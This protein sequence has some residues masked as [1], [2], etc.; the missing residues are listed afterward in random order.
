MS[1]RDEATE[2]VSGTYR[3]LDYTTDV[4]LHPNF[5]NTAANL[6]L[7]ALR[8]SKVKLSWDED[9][10]ERDRITRRTLTRQEIEEN[11]FKAYLASDTESESDGDEGQKKMDR[12]KL[13]ALLL[14][15]GDD[16]LPEGWG[17]SFDDDANDVDMEI[18]FAPGLSTAKGGENET[19]LEKYQRKMKEKKKKRKEEVKEKVKEKDTKEKKVDAPKDDFFADGSDDE[20]EDDEEQEVREELPVKKAKRDK[21]TKAKAQTDHEDSPEQERHAATTEELTL[22]AVS[23]NPNGELKH[24]DMKAVLKAEKAKGKKHK[25]RKD[26]KKTE[27][28]NDLQE[29]FA[30]DVKD[31]RFQAVLEDHTFAIDPSNPQ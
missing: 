8:H 12:E 25:H 24:F 28:G 7:Q 16:T 4:D 20:D 15:G 13:R 27:E 17:A 14:S 5:F 3:P 10:P 2:D 29:D 22:L 21:K 11:D 9:D 23:D 19:T 26:K 18:T 1:P 6:F 31:E 30:I